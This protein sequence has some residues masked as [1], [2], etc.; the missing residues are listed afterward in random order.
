MKDRRQ[1]LLDKLAALADEF[2]DLKREMLN[3]FATISAWDSAR[4]SAKEPPRYDVL[5][6]ERQVGQLAD[7]FGDPLVFPRHVTRQIAE[8]SYGTYRNLHQV[9]FGGASFLQFET[10]FRPDGTM[11][12]TINQCDGQRIWTGIFH[13]VDGP[14]SRG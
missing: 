3:N 13:G 9:P 8:S 1:E 11:R 7:R 5:L 4:A 10:E 14:P 12:L 2:V 6:T